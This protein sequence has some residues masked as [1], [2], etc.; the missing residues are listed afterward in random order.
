MP[1]LEY[2]TTISIPQIAVLTTPELLANI[3]LHLPLVNLLPAQRVSKAWNNIITT[4]PSLQRALF[5]S[6]EPDT[7]SPR[8]NPLLKKHFPI[9]FSEPDNPTKVVRVSGKGI[10]ALFEEEVGLSTGYAAKL[11]REEASWRRM[12]V[13][14]PPVRHADVHWANNGLGDPLLEMLSWG[15][16][17]A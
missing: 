2:Q 10:C 16:V 11:M 8:F 4:M 13:I 1:S 15:L 7:H 12:L 9:W 3:L 17:T 6:P 14:Q 5:L